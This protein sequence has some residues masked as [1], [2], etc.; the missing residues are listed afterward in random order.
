MPETARHR[1]L[2]D[3][4]PRPPGPESSPRPSGSARQSFRGSFLAV[5]GFPVSE[6]H[7]RTAAPAF[8]AWPSW[9][10]PHGPGQLDRRPG[11]SGGGDGS[12]AGV[13][14]REPPAR[15]P[16]G[17]ASEG[18]P[19]P[20]PGG[21]APGPGQGP[22]GGAGRP[23]RHGRHGPDQRQREEL[24]RLHAGEVRGRGL[25]QE[26]T[27]GSWTRGSQAGSR[28]G[29]GAGSVS[30]APPA[31]AAS[32]P[33]RD[34]HPREPGVSEPAPPLRRRVDPGALRRLQQDEGARRGGRHPLRL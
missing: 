28:T 9:P 29:S 18:Q 8:R 27:G 16:R 14:P 2:R 23:E 11:C 32:R 10:P 6:G 26:D 31:A 30:P 34:D 20:G 4:C 5:E 1:R 19:G 13:P 7:G 22:E 24:P 17:G 25:E 15:R 21:A 12:P 3:A 33:L